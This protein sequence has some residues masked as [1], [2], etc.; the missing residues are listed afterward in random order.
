MSVEKNKG[1]AQQAFNSASSPQ[2]AARQR[3]EEQ[4]LGR[5]AEARRQQAAYRKRAERA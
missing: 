4:R 3:A 5:E 2:E 1:R